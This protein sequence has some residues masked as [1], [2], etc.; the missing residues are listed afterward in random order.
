M[1]TLLHSWLYAAKQHELLDRQPDYVH[2]LRYA[3]DVMT[4]ASSAEEGIEILRESEPNLWFVV[5]PGTSA[6]TQ[7]NSGGKD[8]LTS[9]S[10]GAVVA[11]LA[12]L[13]I[14]LAVRFAPAGA[15]S[16]H[17]LIAMSMQSGTATPGGRSSSRR[18][19]RD[20]P[21][22]GVVPFSGVATPTAVRVPD[23]PPQAATMCPCIIL[24]PV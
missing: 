5:A 15:A 3:I 2:A 18:A 6:I 16:R 10:Q 13:L 21:S 7:Q 4:E 11:G 24:E 23:R 1:L 8:Q 14:P 19:A 12:N 22:G 20:A 9:A 17:T